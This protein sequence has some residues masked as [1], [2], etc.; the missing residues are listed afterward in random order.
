[1]WKNKFLFLVFGFTIN[2]AVYPQT[3]TSIKGQNY[4]L[5]TI[6]FTNYLKLLE[7]KNGAIRAKKL[8]VQTVMGQLEFLSAS[9]INPSV[10]ISRGSFFSQVPYTPYE[11]PKSNTVSIS[12]TIEGAGKRDARSKLAKLDIERNQTDF[13][14][15]KVNISKEAAFAFIDT[16]RLKL[17][18]DNCRELLNSLDKQKEK[19]EIAE[20]TE[21]S[22]GIERDL[23]YFAYAM[24]AFVNQ[25][26]GTLLVPLSSDIDF[27]MPEYS[28][29][30]LIANALKNRVDVVNLQSAI[31]YAQASYEL[32]LKNRNINVT[33]SLWVS[34][35]P[36]YVASGS[37]YNKTVAYGFSIS[38]PIPTNLLYDADLIQ[39]SNNKLMLEAG[40]NDLESRVIA[41]VNQAYM[42]YSYAKDKFLDDRLSY[43]NN[44]SADVIK[45]RELKSNLID[46]KVNLLKS[47]INL[48]Q[49][50]GYYY[51]PIN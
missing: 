7:E 36:A 1:M 13:E 34:Q 44:K 4:E 51:F 48:L 20:L 49:N 39:E 47:L 21:L 46:S 5:N 45:K 42:Q 9:N 43:E 35:T 12:G 16:L 30:D 10:S 29:D 32:A 40:L 27:S 14:V 18:L 37:E 50:S 28:V 11:S 19:K 26:N 8:S 22:I 2:F 25:T 33:P 3:I 15:T 38:V 23:R 31:K 17:S 24:N 6:D 41:D